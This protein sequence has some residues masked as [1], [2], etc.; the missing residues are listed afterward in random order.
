[1]R[2]VHR[3]LF[4]GEQIGQGY[5]GDE[6]N[7]EMSAWWLL[8]ALGLYPLQ[9]GTGRY[10]LVAPLFPRATVRPLGGA[11]FSVTTEAT[12]PE[13]DCITGMTV[14]D[15]EHQDSWIDHAD[16]RGEL[17]LRLGAEPTG[18]GGV[19]PAPTAPGE[20]PQPLR[21]LFAADPADPLRDD[22]SRTEQQF[23][24]ASVVID[25]PELGE[26]LQARFLTLT[27]SARAGADPIAWRLEGSDDGR[28]WQTLD[29]RAG[30]SFRWRRQT[31]S[32]EISAPR[33]CT[34]HRLVITA[35][36]GPLRL[37]EVELLA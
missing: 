32:F 12:A 36:E 7:G 35:S 17:Q 13:D 4:V 6:D 5:P 22:D 14:G 16:L 3:R 33:P 27:S 15:R 31:R 9:L 37:A 11:A 29:E 2:E 23:D 30:Q 21:D 18:W 28:T 19:P 25:L 34:H 26:P 24:A 10:H 1:M 20:R 8:T